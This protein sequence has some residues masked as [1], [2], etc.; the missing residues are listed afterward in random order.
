MAKLKGEEVAALRAKDLGKQPGE[1]IEYRVYKHPGKSG[2]FFYTFEIFKP[3]QFKDKDTGEM[4]W[5]K[6]F[7]L[8]GGTVDVAIGFLQQ[9]KQFLNPTNPNQARQ[10]VTGGYNQDPDF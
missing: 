4:R 5:G 8:S 2:G 9:I 3:Y 1:V 6:G 7:E 10:V